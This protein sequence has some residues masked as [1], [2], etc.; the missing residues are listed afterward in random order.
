MLRRLKSLGLPPTELV[1][2]YKTFIL[3]KL[4]YASPAWSSSLL[5]GQK[6]RLERVQKRALKISL[7][8][9]YSKYD[10]ACNA[11]N[12]FPLAIPFDPEN[13]PERTIYHQ[14]LLRFGYK[15]FNHPYHCQFFLGGRLTNHRYNTRYPRIVKEPYAPHDRYKL[16]PLPAIARALNAEE[17]RKKKEKEK[18]EK[19]RKRKNERN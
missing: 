16:S 14:S 11:H 1:N 6:F 17:K 13:H 15:L 12:L 18:K 8:P 3:P 19:E 4:T 10:L 7:G 2:L 5:D 9:S